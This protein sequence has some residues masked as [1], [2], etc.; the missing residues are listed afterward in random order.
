MSLG[1]IEFGVE[2]IC[3]G[4]H[5]FRKACLG[6]RPVSGLGIIVMGF[7]YHPQLRTPPLLLLRMPPLPN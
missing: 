2:G 7:F 1:Q 5:E 3:E 4:G 6:F